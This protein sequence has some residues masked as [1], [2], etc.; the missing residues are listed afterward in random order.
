MKLD[1]QGFEC[2]VLEGM[3]GL[4]ARGEVRALKTEVSRRHLHAQ[5]CSEVELIASLRANWHVVHSEDVSRHKHKQRLKNI[6]GQYEVEAFSPR[7]SH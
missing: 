4:L 7:R 1:A 6:K 3:R 2:R 5:G